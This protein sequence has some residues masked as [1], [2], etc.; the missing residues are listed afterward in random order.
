[1]GKGGHQNLSPVGLMNGTPFKKIIEFEYTHFI[2]RRY[3][4][5]M[6]RMEKK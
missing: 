5:V 6:R 1:M 4:Y 2:Y 3:G